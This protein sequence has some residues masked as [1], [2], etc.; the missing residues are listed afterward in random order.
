MEQKSERRQEGTTSPVP[1]RGV[2]EIRQTETQ[3]RTKKEKEKNQK[4]KEKNER[5]QRELLHL[6]H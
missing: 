6:C 2:H 1:W 4:M 3:K 5:M